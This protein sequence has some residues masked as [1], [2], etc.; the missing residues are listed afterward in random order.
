MKQ[1]ERTPAKV[2]LIAPWA[3]IECLVCSFVTR[4]EGHLA[5]VTEAGSG[6]SAAITKGLA[7]AGASVIVT[8]VDSDSVRASMEAI[9]AAASGTVVGHTLDVT[10]AAACQALAGRVR[11]QTGAISVLVNNAGIGGELRI[12]DPGVLALGD[13]QIAV[14]LSGCS[15]VTRAFVPA[16]RGDRRRDREPCITASFSAVTRS[17]SYMA[18]KPA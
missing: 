10:D 4:L 15:Y 2:Y 18:S 14:N 6:M 1:V 17:F 8:D 3:H 13:R 12:D 16:L 7:E 9:R 5:S 11:T